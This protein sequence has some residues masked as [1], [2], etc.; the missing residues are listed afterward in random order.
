MKTALLK[1]PTI[2]LPALKFR[3]Q[4]CI[5]SAAPSVAFPPCKSLHCVGKPAPAV[6]YA[7]CPAPCKAPERACVRVRAPLQPATSDN[8]AFA[9]WSHVSSQPP[10][11]LRTLGS[12]VWAWARGGFP[13]R[14]G[15]RGNDRLYVR[16]KRLP[17]PCGAQYTVP[18]VQLPGPAVGD[19]AVSGGLHGA[20]KSERW[21]VLEDKGSRRPYFYE[22]VSGRTTWERGE[23][24]WG[25]GRD[26]YVAFT[27]VDPEAAACVAAQRAKG[28][29][30]QLSSLWGRGATGAAAGGVGDRMKQYEDKRR[31]KPIVTAGPKA[32]DLPPERV[33][34][35]TVELR[36]W[37]NLTD[38]LGV[39]AAGKATGV[40]YVMGARS[41]ALWVQRAASQW[42]HPSLVYSRGAKPAAAGGGDG[43]PNAGGTLGGAG[44]QQPGISRAVP[45]DDKF[46]RF[47]HWSRWRR[48]RRAQLN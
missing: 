18:A 7:S 13:W 21:R 44:G 9:D 39:S 22:E 10:L 29:G 45:R 17:P 47:V 2:P 14:V 26:G 37:C 5:C 11:Q 40:R 30:A 20:A 16:F 6:A 15:V 43:A 28:I 33:A 24:T 8:A 48:L 35:A 19:A 31:R 42:E 41:G 23:T 4:L 1:R 46:E 38:A 34:S 25:G 32:A 36:Y 27:V 12:A 3:G